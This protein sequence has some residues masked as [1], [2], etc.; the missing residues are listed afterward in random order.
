MIPRL[1][2]GAFS[3]LEFTIEQL[4]AEGDIVAS[5]VTGRGT[6][7]GPLM[8]M[9]AT[10]RTA[11]W[12]STGFFR[13]RDGKIA[14][15]WGVPDLLGL[16]GQL[17][18]VP[19]PPAEPSP[20]AP[21]PA[22]GGEADPQTSKALL[23]RHEEAFNARDGDGVAEAVADDFVF[24]VMGR[25]IVGAA[26]YRESFAPLWEAF[27]DARNE[28]VHL[29]AEGERVAALVRTTGTNTG[30]FMGLPASGNAVDFLGITFERV[31]GGQRREAWAV[32]DMLG[33]MQQVGAVP[34]PT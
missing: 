33:L 12:A 3:D 22:S 20:P 21:T 2:R 6:N 4:V 27:P 10:G 7:D 34:A 24:H 15:H 1:F 23:R 19:V 28:I 16:L 14:E 25:D 11:Q 17:G 5:L 31:S 13:V 32:P 18:A 26:A 30:S 9:P 29:V 8:G